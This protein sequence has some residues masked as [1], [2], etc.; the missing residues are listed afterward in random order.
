VTALIG[1]KRVSLHPLWSQRQ[2]TKSNG[3]AYPIQKG[4]EAVYSPQGKKETEAQIRSYLA[5][6][7]ALSQGLRK[8]GYKC[9]GGIDSPYI[10]WKTPK[11]LGSWEFFNLLLEKCHL[12]SIPGVGFGSEGEGYVRLSCFTTKEK[13][14]E[15][16]KRI[17]SL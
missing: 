2:N 1:K 17:N 12:I 14:K 5:Q 6:G 8:M 4:A 3:V 7:E 9:V 13:A 10:W 11:G 15:A 16:L